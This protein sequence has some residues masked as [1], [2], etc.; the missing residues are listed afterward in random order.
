MTDRR[1]RGPVV[2]LM[3]PTA[4]GK[5]ELAAALVE[6]LP[7]EIV[8]VDSAMVYR[9]MDIGTGKPGAELLARAPHRLIDIREPRDTYSAA[10]FRAD[11]LVAIDEIRRA[12]RVPLLVGGTGLYFR[13]LERGLSP[14]PPAE[15]AIRERLESEAKKH[16]WA[17]LHA[18]LARL[19]PASAARIH[20]N[21]PQRIQRAL[22][23]FETTGRPMSAMIDEAKPRPTGF[24]V[25]KLSLEP[26]RREWLHRRIAGRFRGM[27]AKGLVEE[28]ETLRESGRLEAG[29]PALRAVGYRQVWAHLDGRWDAEELAERGIAATRQLARRQLTWLR[30]DPDIQRFGCDAEGLESRVRAHVAG[31]LASDQP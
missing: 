20:V 18:R 10:Q 1:D 13:A 22:E 12:G 4:A 29:M 5:T 8:S 28:V 19:D 25:H 21:D 27:L 23:V 6:R 9:G 14:L 15:P 7:L 3:G 30:A 31:I 2:F 16:G 24:T 11:A 26:E 17:S